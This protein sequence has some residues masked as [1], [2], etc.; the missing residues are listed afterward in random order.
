MKAAAG[1][2][3]PLAGDDWPAAT[4]PPIAPPVAAAAIVAA[5]PPVDAAWLVLDPVADWLARFAVPAI[6][7][8]PLGDAPDALAGLAAGCAVCC[9]LASGCPDDPAEAAAGT[10]VPLAGAAWLVL[11][12]VPDW[13][14]GLTVPDVVDDP[15]SDAP[16]A[17]TGLAAGCA[18]CCGL[19]SGCADDPVE[20]ATRTDVPLAGDAWLPATAP[21]IAPPAAAAAL[22]AAVPP[23]DAAWLVLDPVADWLAGFIDPVGAL[24]DAVPAWLIPDVADVP[25]CDAPDAPAGLAVGCPVCCSLASGCAADPAEAA[26]GAD[27]PLAGDD[28]LPATAPPIAPPAAAAAIVDAVPP[29]DAAWLVLDPVADWLAGL[30][31]PAVAD[32]PLCDAPDAPTGLAV[33]CAVCCGLFSGCAADPVPP[34]GLKLRSVM[35]SGLLLQPLLRLLHRLLRLPS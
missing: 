9:G 22:V 33:G 30:T 13:L 29:I 3:V 8:D 35:L 21:P 19:A 25:L 23:V 27:V 26:A 16:D 12:P 20:A 4:V 7:D 5:V 11:D 31:V 18:V 34:Q 14:A 32:A 10:D 2:D 28:W 24:V 1:A 6:V 17:P 15:L